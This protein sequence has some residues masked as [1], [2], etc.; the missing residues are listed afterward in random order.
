MHKMRLGAAVAEKKRLRES[1]RAIEARAKTVSSAASSQP[2]AATNDNNKRPAEEAQEQ[3]AKRRKT[4]PWKDGLCRALHY[5]SN[6][7]HGRFK[8][9]EFKHSQPVLTLQFDEAIPDYWGRLIAPSMSGT[10]RTR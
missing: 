7:R 10:F 1:R 8:T 5:Q 6:W 9:L 3:V 2:S 4:R